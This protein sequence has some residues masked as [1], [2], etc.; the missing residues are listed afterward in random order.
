MKEKKGTSERRQTEGGQSGQISIGPSGAAASSSDTPKTGRVSPRGSRNPVQVGDQAM[1]DG[2][3][4]PRA[5]NKRDPE[6]DSI[7]IGSQI[8]PKRSRASP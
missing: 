5:G 2:D 4:T 6:D 7:D 8:I 1:T 3:T